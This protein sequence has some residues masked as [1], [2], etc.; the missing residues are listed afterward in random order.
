M[1]SSKYIYVDDDLNDIL[2]VMFFFGKRVVS[3]RKAHDVMDE[4]FE[5]VF[6]LACVIKF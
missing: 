4:F 2:L 3:K 1:S 6:V 5:V